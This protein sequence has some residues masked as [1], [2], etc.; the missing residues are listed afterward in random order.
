[1]R[2]APN[3]A[4]DRLR[5]CLRE[6]Y[7]LAAIT[8]EFL[9]RGHDY[10]AGVYR[11]AGEQGSVYLL[12]VTSRPLYAPSCL[13]PRYLRDQGISAVVAPLPT[14]SGSSWTTVAEWTVIVYPFLDGESTLTGMTSAHWSA[15]GAIFRQIHQ[16]PLPPAGFAA[17]RTERFDPTGYVRWVRAFET[18]H[19]AAR[20]SDSGAVRDLCAAWEAHR[21]TI[22]T[23]L[24]FLETLSP[25]LQAATLPNVI[26]H[27]DLHTANL[28]R[29]P[30]GRVFVIDWDEVMLAPK[31]RDFIFIREPHADA[32]W[33]GYG[34]H[35]MDWTALTYFHWERVVQD[36]IEEAQQVVFRG[37]VGEEAKAT[38]V[39]RFAS[40][41][42]AGN[43]VDAAK[44][45]A[46][47][48]PRDLRVSHAPGW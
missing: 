34:P 5:T 32:F 41:F 15:V 12:K 27:A 38:A 24:T 46:D 18:D 9:P 17:V 14:T 21:S 16:V 8:L 42:A 29:D 6:Q 36:L 7:A 33:M 37:E 3:I 1:V 48:L 11:V 39:Q 43:N 10:L 45:A 26:C 44:A 4:V 30:A 13:I 2:E 25:A 23:G 40:T 47:H 19:L 28:L 22:D 20:P 31:E 35:A